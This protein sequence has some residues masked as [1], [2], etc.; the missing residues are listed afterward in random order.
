MSDETEDQD[1]SD[2]YPKLS[3]AVGHWTFNRNA[4]QGPWEW[5][6]YIQA[7]CNTMDYHITADGM[8]IDFE[9]GS[10]IHTNVTPRELFPDA[11]RELSD[12]QLVHLVS[13]PVEGLKYTTEEMRASFNQYLEAKARGETK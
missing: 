13:L 9:D 1:D 7:E 4:R 3:E 11:S 10:C 5:Y 6:Y 2:Y 8:S 12:D